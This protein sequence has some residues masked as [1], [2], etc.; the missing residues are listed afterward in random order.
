MSI[1]TMID[2]AANYE[3]TQGLTEPSEAVALVTPHNTTELVYPGTSNAIP[4]R[5]IAFAVAG[6]IKI[7]DARGNTVTIPSGVLAAGIIHP[8]RAKRI[9]ATGTTATSIVAFW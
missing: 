9:H 3:K 6:A 4:C 7:D 8:I 5:G 1:N 2:T